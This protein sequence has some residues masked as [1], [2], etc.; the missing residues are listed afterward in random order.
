MQ[1]TTVSPTLALTE[2][3]EDASRINALVCLCMGLPMNALLCWVIVRHSP[4]ELRV[5]RKVLLQT[6]AVDTAYLLISFLV[7]PVG[8]NTTLTNLKR[9]LFR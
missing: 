9:V 5:Y 4:K 1:S 7:Q 3:W 8:D 2:F 6:A